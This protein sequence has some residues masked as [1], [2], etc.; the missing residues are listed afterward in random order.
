MSAGADIQELEGKEAQQLGSLMRGWG[1][2][3]GIGK[4]A[5]IGS[6]CRQLLL[7]V[8]EGHLRK[9]DIV[10]Y[11]GKWTTTGS[12]IQYLRE[13]AVLQAICSSLDNNQVS[14]D[15]GM[16]VCMEHTIIIHQYLGAD[17]LARHGDPNCE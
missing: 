6:L 2:N 3:K 12:G 14:E 15:N 17:G 4:G 10:S 16:E 5:A 9:E 8:K 7:S 13:L 1:I 11:R